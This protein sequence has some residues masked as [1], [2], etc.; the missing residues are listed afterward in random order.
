MGKKVLKYLKE[1]FLTIVSIFVSSFI[2][3]SAYTVS[4]ESQKISVNSGVLRY[5]IKAS[6]DKN[7]D[8][9]V[10]IKPTVGFIRKVSYI[11]FSDGKV[12]GVNVSDGTY[13]ENKI[14]GR[15]SA[16]ST[17]PSELMTKR[18][19]KQYVFCLVEGGNGTRYLSMV[20]T[21]NGKKPIVYDELQTLN[22]S[23]SPEFNDFRNLR[24][25]LLQDKFIAG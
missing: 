18:D 10:T 5:E 23:E 9:E 14:E 2:A 8:L 11:K 25:K 20:V 3:F 24:N 6:M 7:D 13:T 21:R 22:D 16:V 12:N 1:N 17:I 19:A 4:K 15:I